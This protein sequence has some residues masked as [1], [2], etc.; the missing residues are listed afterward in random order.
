MCLIHGKERI[1]LLVWVTAVSIGFYGIRGG[2]FTI[3]T[4]GNYRVYGPEETFIAD[5]NQLGLALTMILPLLYYS[6]RSS[7]LTRAA[8]SWASA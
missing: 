5:N 3:L 6:S 2:I 8:R 7:A 1:Q 4:G